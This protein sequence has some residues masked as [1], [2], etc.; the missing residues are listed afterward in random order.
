MSNS[1]IPKLI[2]ENANMMFYNKGKKGTVFYKDTKK[3]GFV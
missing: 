3:G 1:N 2:A